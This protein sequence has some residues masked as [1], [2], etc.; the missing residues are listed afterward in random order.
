M[1][2]SHFWSWLN[3]SKRHLA[4]SVYRQWRYQPIIDLLEDRCLLSVLAVTNTNATGTGSLAGQVAAAQ[5][6]DEI[7]FDPAAF[8]SVTS[9]QTI[10]PSA[11][12]NINK[13]LT[14]TGPGANLLTVSGV[15]NGNHAVFTITAGSSVTISGLKITGGNNQAGSGGGIANAGT[16]AILNCWITG[17]TSAGGLV[18][19][20]FGGGIDSS[21]PAL[22]ISGSTIS[23]NTSSTSYQ[24]GFAMGGGIFLEGGNNSIVNSTIYQNTTTASG[25]EFLGRSSGGGIFVHNGTTTIVNS[26]ITLNTATAIINITGGGICSEGTVNLVNTIVANNRASIGPDIRG[27][28][29]AFNNLVTSTAGSVGVAGSPGLV[30]GDPLLGPLQNNGGATLTLALQAG[31]PAIGKGTGN[32]GGHPWASF[33]DQRDL[34]RSANAI[35]IGAFQTQNPALAAST[36][37]AA[38][39][40]SPSLETKT[41]VSL[42]NLYGANIQVRIA[43]GDINGDGVADLITA[44]GPGGPSVIFVF[45]GKTGAQL[46]SFAA[47][48]TGQSADFIGQSVQFGTNS[49]GTNLTVGYFVGAGDVNAD[50]FADVIIGFDG[51]TS[52]PLVNVYSGKVIASGQDPAFLGQGILASYNAFPPPGGTVQFNGGVR[53]AAG[54]MDGDGRAEVIAVPGVGGGPLVSVYSGLLLTQTNNLNNAGF[55]ISFNAYPIAGWPGT[56]LFVACGDIDHDGFRDLILGPGGSGGG[57]VLL[58]I[59]GRALLTQFKL[60]P[61]TIDSTVVSVAPI[62]LPAVQYA[63]PYAFPNG[64]HV[65]TADLNSDGFA[66]ILLGGGP[67]NGALLDTFFSNTGGTTTQGTSENVFGATLNGIFAAGAPV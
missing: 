31:S 26:T 21:G 49:S 36:L 43:F 46:A 27:P 60:T 34:P 8:S 29:A 16:L 58:V 64:I 52:G 17:N 11:T 25:T 5:P 59:S 7:V 30:I 44:A 33:V 51:S 50:G 10:K 4:G 63:P 53:V 67:G 24:F 13:S 20:G 15:N 23:N 28:V 37:G 1:T 66:D 41:S 39:T 62:A 45:D 65:A 3:H 54:D 9:P 12:L 48:T 14:I 42:T 61:T 57:Q 55:L 19:S 47:I 2:T 32:P 38:I 18:A 56:G 22:T 6:G 35:D 40:L